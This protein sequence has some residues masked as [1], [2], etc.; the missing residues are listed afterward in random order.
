MADA[1]KALIVQG[2]WDGHEPKQVAEVFR[3]ACWPR[4]G[5]DVE[6]ADTLDAFTD[7]AKLAGLSL[8]VPVWTMARSAASR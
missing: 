5:F 3:R 2:G 4:R 8:I 1:R 6:V 7:E